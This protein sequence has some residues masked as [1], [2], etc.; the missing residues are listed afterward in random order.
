[1]TI[2]EIRTALRR[3]WYLTLVVLIVAIVAAYGIHGQAAGVPTGNATVQ[4]L[5]DSPSSSLVNVNVNSVGL[6]AQ[7]GVIAQAMTS[8]AVLTSIAK[9]AGV[10]AAGLTAEGPYSGAA[11]VL[12]IP[13]PS[14]AR[15]MQLVSIKPAF[16]LA[17]L[18]QQNVPIITVSVLGP[19]P[20]SAGKVADAVLPG[21]E[22]WLSTIAAQDK[23]GTQNQIVLRQLGDAEAGYVNS[24]AATALAAI[25]AVAMIIFGLVAVVQIDRRIDRRRRGKLGEL[26]DALETV[27]HESNPAPP[28]ARMGDVDTRLHDG[29]RRMKHAYG[30]DSR[31]LTGRRIVGLSTPHEGGSGSTDGLSDG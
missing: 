23:L 14:E 15:G 21:V 9:S 7:A 28:Y 31:L 27:S 26:E 13:T 16:H 3:R 22:A 25:A 20:T 12:D 11:E 29:Q 5:V 30:Q 2:S 17:F 6:E 10:P 8:N 1:M 4:I 24:S 18:A 19:T